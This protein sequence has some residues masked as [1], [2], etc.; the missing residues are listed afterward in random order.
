[1]GRGVSWAAVPCAHTGVSE[2]S[3]AETVV[4]QWQMG[5][6]VWEKEQPPLRVCS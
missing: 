6:S 2:L 4:P 1:M 3:G 5:N